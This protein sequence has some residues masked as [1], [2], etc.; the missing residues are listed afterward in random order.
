MCEGQGTSSN[1]SLSANGMST[2]IAEK[3]V[4]PEVGVSVT[5][6]K[7]SKWVQ[8]RDHGVIIPGVEVSATKGM[9][10]HVAE[11]GHVLKHPKANASNL[12]V[13]LE[14][15][16]QWFLWQQKPNHKIFAEQPPS[17]LTPFGGSPVAASSWACCQNF[18]VYVEEYLGLKLETMIPW[19]ASLMNSVGCAFIEE[20][21]GHSC[22]RDAEALLG[23]MLCLEEH[24]VAATC[25][26]VRRIGAAFGDPRV[27][28]PGVEGREGASGVCELILTQGTERATCGG[29][30]A[31][32]Y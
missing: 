2:I 11:E 3:K 26:G 12:K 1:S 22:G 25:V 5:Q 8:E 13:T 6:E 18:G 30:A 9:T 27:E 19:S 17:Y 20:A 31:P 29:R 7:K 28:D 24:G 16:V 14:S 32:L 23:M 4:V 15:S 10:E 21:E